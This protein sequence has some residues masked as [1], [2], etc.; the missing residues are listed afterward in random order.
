MK[1]QENALRH[2]KEQPSIQPLDVFYAGSGYLGFLYESQL[3]YC[4]QAIENA[5]ASEQYV[6]LV[7]S[8]Q[9]AHTLAVE[10]VSRVFARQPLDEQALRRF[11]EINGEAMGKLA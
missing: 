5:D 4:K 7:E 2:V 1:D 9:A 11:Q 8:L 10:V 6:Q 3:V